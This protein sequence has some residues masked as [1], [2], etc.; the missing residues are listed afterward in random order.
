ML[1][2]SEAG[3]LEVR[4][5]VV[6]AAPP[7]KV[8]N[9]VIAFS[10]LPPPTEWLFKVGIAYPLRATL[11]GTGPGA[12]RHC[13]FTTGPFVEPIEV[14][15]APRLLRFGVTQNPP[16]MEEWTPYAAVHPPHLEGFLVSERGQFR[17]EALPDGRTRLE[18]TTWYRHHMWPERYWQWWSDYII[19]RIHLRV[20]NHIKACSET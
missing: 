10:E 13:V 18:G 20:L 9:N 4:S 5:A 8:W 6:I 1:F 16:P 19:H 3:L 14:W 2:R 11:Y 17:L 15:D 12:I 7:D